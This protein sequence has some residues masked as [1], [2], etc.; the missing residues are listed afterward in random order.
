MRSVEEVSKRRIDCM[1]SGAS[2]IIRL[3]SGSSHRNDRSPAFSTSASKLTSPR[4]LRTF[5]AR[6][7]MWLWNVV[8]KSDTMWATSVT[9]SAYLSLTRVQQYWPSC[10]KSA[11]DIHTGMRHIFT[12][13]RRCIHR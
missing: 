2:R 1:G 3:M 12:N 4:G 5:F 10:T 11:S 6:S 13:A 7:V 8:L 9:T